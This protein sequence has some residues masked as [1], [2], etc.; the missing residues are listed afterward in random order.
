[1]CV[2]VGIVAQENVD[3]SSKLK[4]HT[5][6]VDYMVLELRLNKEGEFRTMEEGESSLSRIA[7]DLSILFLFLGVIY[8]LA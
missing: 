6:K 3:L 2:T 5:K 4:A 7:V 8:L 1:M